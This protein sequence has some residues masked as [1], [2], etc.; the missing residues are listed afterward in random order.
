[1]VHVIAGMHAGGAEH[2]LLRLLGELSDRFPATVCTLGDPGVL[3]PQVEALGIEVWSAGIEGAASLVSGA[4]RLCERLRLRRPAVVQ[5]WMYHADLLGGLAAR[6]ARV[7][8]VAW[9]V[10]TTVLDK[11]TEKPTTRAAPYLAACLSRVVPDRIVCASHAGRLAHEA[12]GYP[13]SKM[14]VIPNG[15]PIPAAADRHA[16]RAALRLHEDDLAIG[17]IGRVAPVKGQAVLL[18]AFAQL[19]RSHPRARLVLCGSGADLGNGDLVRQMEVL[20]ITE[21]VTLLGHRSDVEAVHAALD[22][23]CSPSLEEGFP[24]AVAEA[25]A[26]GIPVVATDVGDTA[27]VLAGTGLLVRP[28]DAAELAEALGR[29]LDRPVAERMS[30]GAGAREVAERTLSLAA[31]AE[32]YAELWTAMA[33]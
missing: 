4:A 33:S 16:M 20:G 23:V 12:L 17:R 22:V 27:R 32:A 18:D 24:N 13:P 29:M 14:V 1:V 11:A 6:V 3:A 7:G 31:M 26:A 8:P 9:N 15:I 10:R 19:V 21:R 30:M 5:T 25:M 28:G 2:A